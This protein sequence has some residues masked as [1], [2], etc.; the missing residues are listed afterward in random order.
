MSG[1]PKTMN[2]LPALYEMRLALIL[3]AVPPTFTEFRIH[4]GNPVSSRFDRN[5]RGSG[6]IRPA[7]EIESAD[8]SADRDKPDV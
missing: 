7:D 2:R 8:R 6:I 1:S 3:R 5:D 4:R